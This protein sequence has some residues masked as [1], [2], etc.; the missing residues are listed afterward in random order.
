M[1]G[2]GELL[3][4][5]AIGVLV[6]GGRKLPELGKSLGSTMKEFKKGLNGEEDPRP[7]RDVNDPP[8]EKS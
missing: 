2:W 1:L 6:F 7:I 5:L 3:V 8:D 4:V